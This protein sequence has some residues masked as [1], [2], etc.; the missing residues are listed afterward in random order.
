MLA[1]LLRPDGGRA[2]VF[3]HDIVC[4]G[5]AVRRQVMN[6]SGGMRRYVDIATSLILRP[7]LLFLD[8]PTTELDPRSR[9]Q[10]W[11]IVRAIIT[12][13]TTV[14]LT[15]QYLEGADWPASRIAVIDHG[16]VIA[17]GTSAE[18]KATVGAGRLQVRLL[19][20]DAREQAR[21]L[22]TRK[23]GSSILLESD[24]AVRSAQIATD[25]DQHELGTRTT[26]APA[27]LSAAGI[28]ISQFA[29]AQPSLDEAFL[30]LTGRTAG[31]KTA[32]TP[33]MS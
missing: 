32:T 23:L 24:P 13:G 15:T 29:L 2:R 25:D 22:L 28:A 16:K 17:E 21:Q 3:G 26:R 1:T 27:A 5:E 14:V 11:E 18:L 9:R 7:A 33:E 8:E 31:P 6:L 20:P 10:T 12:E 4:E 30:T 19:D